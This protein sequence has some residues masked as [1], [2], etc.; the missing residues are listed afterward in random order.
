VKPEQLRPVPHRNVRDLERP[1]QT[2]ERLLLQL[3]YGRRAL[4]KYSERRLVQDEANEGNALLLA[5]A[6]KVLPHVDGV[7]RV[8]LNQVLQAEHLQQ[9]AY[10]VI[11][12]AA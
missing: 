9:L 2:V 3:V 7:K 1:Q 11:K 4:V 6:E 10:A 5:Q 8:Q 12:H